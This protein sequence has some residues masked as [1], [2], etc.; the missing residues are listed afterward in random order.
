MPL[1]AGRLRPHS[2]FLQRAWLR[3]RSR[4]LRCPHCLHGQ[5]AGA[6]P[7]LPERGA[8]HAAGG[9]RALPAGAAGAA[10]RDPPRL[11]LPF[12]RRFLPAFARDGVRHRSPDTG[13]AVVSVPVVGPVQQGGP[14][15]AHAQVPALDRLQQPLQRVLGA[16]LPLPN[17]LALFG[18][19]RICQRPRRLRRRAGVAG[20]YLRLY[21]LPQRQQGGG[22]LPTVQDAEPT[23]NYR[24]QVAPVRARGVALAA[25]IFQYGDLEGGGAADAGRPAAAGGRADPGD[26]AAP[27]AAAAGAA[28][29]DHRLPPFRA[30]LGAPGAA[31]AAV[32][33]PRR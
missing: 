23:V 7:R 31:R 4:E 24:P 29:G 28:G 2:G 27:G 26:G 5:L 25:F 10:P 1:P 30:H 6:G 33:G 11:P 12:A 20:Q 15:R 18:D 8:A 22:Q 3:R 17:P 19:R 14:G 21:S 13:A 32:V 9:R 16:A